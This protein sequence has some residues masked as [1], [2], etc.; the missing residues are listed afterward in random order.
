MALILK[1]KSLPSLGLFQCDPNGIATLKSLGVL[2]E[3]APGFFALWHGSKGYK[4]KLDWQA[5]PDSV[6]ADLNSFMLLVLSEIEKDKKAGKGVAP[7]QTSAPSAPVPT[8]DVIPLRD[9]K[10]MYQKVHGTSAKSVYVVVALHDD[11][12]IAA[13]IEGSSLSVRAEGPALDLVSVTDKLSKQG[14]SLKNKTTF[15]YMSGHYPCNDDAPPNKVLGA[16]LLGTGIDFDS[17]MPKVSKVKELG[18]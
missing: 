18:S 4:L 15:K 12:K 13:R 8:S 11:L 6:K 3:A 9:A 17:P 7:V 14:L 5:S 16:I 2:E 10:A 1:K